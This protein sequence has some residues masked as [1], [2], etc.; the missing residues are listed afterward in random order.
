M[1]IIPNNIYKGNCLEVMD[2]IPDNSVD[3][4]LCDLPY[5]TTIA[6]WDIVIPFNK[7]IINDKG[8]FIYENEFLLEQF[9]NNKGYQYN[10]DKFDLESKDGLWQHYERITKENSPI[11]L[12]GSEPFTSLLISS[13]L[14]MFKYRITWDKVA[15]TGH[16]NANKMPMQ[17]VEDICVFYKKPP[18][19]FPQF[20]QKTEE[21]LKDFVA[22]FTGKEQNNNIY[23]NA[24]A[25]ELSENFDKRFPTNLVRFNAKSN[26]CNGRNRI[27]PTQKLLELLEYLIE[28]YSEKYDVILDNTCGVGSSLI[29][30]KNKNRKYIG[31]EQDQK[32]FDLAVE[33]INKTKENQND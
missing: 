32:Y 15:V 2:F 26:E 8:K 29:A 7:Y 6:K 4:V 11:I 10:K 12:F 25:R 13:N 23:G 18:K 17:Q 1:E 31:I 5:G 9:K 30:A 3:M 20:Q 16:L 21:N 22:K 14:K 33:R 19:Y 28:T 27:H 24:K